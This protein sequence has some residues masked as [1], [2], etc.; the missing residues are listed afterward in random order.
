[1]WKYQPGKYT[2]LNVSVSLSLYTPVNISLYTPVNV[3]LYTLISMLYTLTNV[4]LSLSLSLSTCRQM[5]LSLSLSTH[6]QM[7]LSTLALLPFAS[8]ERERESNMFFHLAVWRERERKQVF[9]A[10]RLGERERGLEV[11]PSSG[12][13]ALLNRAEYKFPWTLI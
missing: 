1:L 13:P 11:L 2:P 10:W 5:S 3:S 8:V 7:S 6:R 4:S 9:A 12:T